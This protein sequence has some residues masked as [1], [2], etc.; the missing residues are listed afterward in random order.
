VHVVDARKI[1]DAAWEKLAARIRTFSGGRL[2]LDLSRR[3]SPG[4]ERFT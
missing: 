4:P 3:D 2:V 1:S